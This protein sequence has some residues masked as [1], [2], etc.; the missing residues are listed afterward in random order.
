M[1][2][3]LLV[4]GC[5]L[6]WKHYFS[7][8]FIFGS[9]LSVSVGELVKTAFPSYIV[10]TLPV[11]KSFTCPLGFWTWIHKGILNSF[12][13]AA[14][15]PSPLPSWCLGRC[16]DYCGSGMWL[17]KWFEETH[18]RRKHCCYLDLH[19]TRLNGGLSVT[20][21]SVFKLFLSK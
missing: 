7:L 4:I 12:W 10:M 11:V 19:G 21:S 16:L 1:S 6:N 9:M 18:L 8:A 2:Y 14:I 17:T 15:W 3:L 5:T 13:S 20:I